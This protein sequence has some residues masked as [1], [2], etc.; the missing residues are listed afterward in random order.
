M[1]MSGAS[2]TE[3]TG[4]T[5]A[6][7]ARRR[8]AFNPHRQRRGNLRRGLDGPLNVGTAARTVGPYPFLVMGRLTDQY[9]QPASTKLSPASIKIRVSLQDFTSTDA[10]VASVGMKQTAPESPNTVDHVSRCI[11]KVPL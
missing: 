4:V 10:H 7:S 11:A 6:S 1:L 2:T 9:E 3:I 8:T 5:A